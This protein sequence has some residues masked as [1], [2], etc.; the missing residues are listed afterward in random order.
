MGVQVKTENIKSETVRERAVE[1]RDPSS[2][3][4]KREIKPEPP[5]HS[6]PF[7]P[8]SPDLMRELRLGLSNQEHV[9]E[10]QKDGKEGISAL[11]TAFPA[12][13]SLACDACNYTASC[14]K[15]YQLHVRSI[16]HARRAARKLQQE[17]TELAHQRQQR[18]QN[19]APVKGQKW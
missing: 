12:D 13:G 15:T 3:V 17:D 4:L 14:R 6:L 18:E 5:D 2:T 16:L 19:Q 10:K 7:L 1:I 11:L 9:E 8:P